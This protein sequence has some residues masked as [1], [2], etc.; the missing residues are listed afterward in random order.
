MSPEGLNY[1]HTGANGVLKHPD[2]AGLR[3]MCTALA[4]ADKV[5]LYFHG[6]LVDHDAGMEICRKLD[7]EFRKAEAIPAFFVWES[8]FFETVKNNLG[9]IAK[10]EIFS[11]LVKKLVSF[12]VG[13]L[14]TIGG[15]RDLGGPDLPNETELAIEL[16][17]ASA[18]EEPYRG[19]EPV[20]DLR[21]LT[22]SELE[23]FEKALTEDPALQE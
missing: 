14:T 7:P 10:E 13:K 4:E 22:K 11:G 9:E 19:L 3:H 18:G 16:K 21:E 5:V 20:A 17:K 6:G 8:G 1:I 23:A 15:G 12:V 2:E